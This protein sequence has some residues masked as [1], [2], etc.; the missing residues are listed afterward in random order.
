MMTYEGLYIHIPFCVTKCIYC[1]FNS[2]DYKMR[3]VEDYLKAL[4]VDFQRIHPIQP[5]TIFIGGGTPTSLSF[6]QLKRFFQMFSREV[7]TQNTVEFT[8]EANPGTVDL[9]KL[10]LL[11]A[12]GINRISFGAQSFQPHLLQFLGRIHNVRQ[13]G[14]AVR[15]AKIAG[16]TN[17]SM[18]LIFGI[19][20]QTLELLQKDLDQAFELQ[21]THLSIYNLI[22]ERGTFLNQLRYR[23]KVQPLEESLELEMF[24]RIREETIKAHFQQY[25]LSNYS[26]PGYACQHNLLYWRLGTYQAVGPGAHGFDGVRRF[27]LVQNLQKYIEKLKQGESPIVFSEKISPEQKLQEVLLMGL[28]RTQ[29]LEESE[30]YF[31]TGHRLDY[32]EDAYPFL[33]E[34][35]WILQNHQTL[36]LTPEGQKMSDGVLSYLLEKGHPETAL[37]TTPAIEN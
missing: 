6:S 36:Q 4:E 15:L 1:D 7:D 19:P 31:H 23:K 9:Q 8:I 29:G 28:R 35:G 33:K 26:H 11:L 3:W 12:H 25:E 13:I 34:Q 16:F 18:D 10:E 27:S 30:L 24:D 5:R 2:I 22:Y 14:E 20:G 32:F 17:T 21:T 37:K